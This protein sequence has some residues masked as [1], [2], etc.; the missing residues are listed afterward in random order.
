MWKKLSVS[1]AAAAV[2]ACCPLSA[3]ESCTSAKCHDG[4]KDASCCKPMAE[5][6][7]M[8]GQKTCNPHKK[9]VKITPIRKTSDSDPGFIAIWEEYS[10]TTEG[11]AQAQEPSG[12]GA[13]K[14]GASAE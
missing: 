9:I 8:Q 6:C 2:A 10:V 12:T 3:G 11:P 5:P 7:A 4:K 13:G 14:T 1:L